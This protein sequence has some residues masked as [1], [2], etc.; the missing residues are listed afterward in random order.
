M[1]NVGHTLS[2]RWRQFTTGSINRRIFNAVAVV[3]VLT[4]GV[5]LVTV[6]REII[7]ARTFGTTD[8]LEAFLVAFSLP[9]FTSSVVATSFNAALIPIYIQV[10][11]RDGQK[12]AQQLLSGVVILSMGLLMIMTAVLALAGAYV[13]PILGSSFGPEKL[14]LTRNL[15]Y[16]LLPTI[17]ISG[18]ATFWGA[19][20]NALEHF[21]LTSIASVAIPVGSVGFLFAFGSVWG[22]YALAVGVIVGYLLQL[23]LLAWGLIQQGV[24]VWPRWHGIGPDIWRVIGQYTPMVAASMIM[25]GT[26]L[27]DQAMAATLP[28]GSIAALNYGNRLVALLL[29]SARWH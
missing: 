14:A 4:F 12:A 28:S 11:E 26:A 1:G 9:M 5:R 25:G 10:R 15:F 22:I 16:I 17:A 18:L 27:V 24:E 3:G 2:N 8:S 13:L 20:L 21:A 6:L 23:I 19:V 7:V 29:A